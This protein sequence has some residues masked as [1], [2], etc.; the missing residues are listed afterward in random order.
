MDGTSLL[1]TLWDRFRGHKLRALDEELMKSYYERQEILKEIG[2]ARLELESIR[3]DKD[4][5]VLQLVESQNDIATLNEKFV[6]EEESKV[7]AV[8]QLTTLGDEIVYLKG[9][10]EIYQR[11]L[12]L[13]P[14]ERQEQPRQAQKPLRSAR[15]PFAIAE[16]KAQTALTEQYWRDRAA[17]AS[18]GEGVTGKTTDTPTV[19]DKEPS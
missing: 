10:V 11:R 16:A 19:S 6:T 13:L 8:A 18:V 2:R 9:Q 17:N 7:L 3:R 14:Q 1:Q 5:L 12:G 4:T 15:V